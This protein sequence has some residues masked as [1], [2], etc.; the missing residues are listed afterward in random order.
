MGTFFFVQL[1][2][3]FIERTSMPIMQLAAMLHRIYALPLLIFA[4]IW[5]DAMMDGMDTHHRK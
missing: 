2:Q 1:K 3:S 4:W 5:V